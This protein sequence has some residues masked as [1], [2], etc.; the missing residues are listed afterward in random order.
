MYSNKGLGRYKA[1]YKFADRLKNITGS[2]IRQI[3][4]LLEDP[5]IISFA[6][7]NP[8]PESFPNKDIAKIATGI[9]KEQGKTVLQYGGTIGM[10]SLM[11]TVAKRLSN[12]GIEA[13]KEEVIIISGSSQGIDLMSKAF[14]NPGDRVLVESPTFLGALQT[15]LIYQ[16]DL[17]SVDTDKKGL[18]PSDLEKKIKQHKPKFLYTIP[19]FQNP[20]GI[21]M[22][23]E[24]R[25][26]VLEI[27]EKAGVLIL[28]DD[29]Y[30]DL[31]Y[32][33][34]ALPPIKSYDKTGN[35][36]YLF[37]FSKIISPG[38]RVGAAV[39]DKSIIAKFNICKQG[40]DV[41]TSN[42]SQAIADE[43]CRSGKLPGHIKDINKMYKR[44]MDKMI[45]LM[46]KLFPK[47]VKHTAPEGGLFIWAE[48]PEGM[49]ALDIFKKA[50]EKKVA[51]VPGTHFYCE[52]GH[53]NTMRLNFSMASV[54]KIEEG[55]KR[56]AQVIRENM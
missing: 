23:E 7:G 46:D 17:R 49:D 38:L 21:T 41:H 34:K 35:V 43:Y 20:T 30:R 31:R 24:R 36:I 2:A 37:S 12:I 45:E 15:F 28:E 26:E 54:E 1:M 33:G 53:E 13:K 14:I 44:Q 6:G 50:V 16:A 27:C 11:E 32:S 56:L 48:L 4:M 55:M 47:G 52:G 18:I 42:L 9:L 51:F 10:P 29:P 39:A 8:S 40:V 19:T 25:K 22:A 5:D 3:F